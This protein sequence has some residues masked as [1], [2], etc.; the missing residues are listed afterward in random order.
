M[1][2][3]NNFIFIYNQQ[4]IYIK[5]KKNWAIKGSSARTR[6]SWGRAEGLFRSSCYF[7]SPTL[8]IFRL[9]HRIQLI[10]AHLNLPHPFTI[11]VKPPVTI[12]FIFNSK[13]FNCFLHNKKKKL[14][15][16]SIGQNNIHRLIIKNFKELFLLFF[17]EK[18]RTLQKESFLKK[19]NRVYKIKR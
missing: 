5:K 15:L 9:T 2:R 1:K 4:K 3:P 17:E 6:M 8:Q 10:F 7:S 16:L 14:L 11:G 13:N 19:C 18:G 12:S